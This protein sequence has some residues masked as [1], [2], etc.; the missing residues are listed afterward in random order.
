MDTAT[1]LLSVAEAAAFLRLQPSTLRS[2]ILNRRISFIKLGR[3]VFL[4]RSDL[5]NLISS[6]VIPARTREEESSTENGR[7]SQR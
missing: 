5:N 2:W 1:N 3:R 4:R 6:S 7:N